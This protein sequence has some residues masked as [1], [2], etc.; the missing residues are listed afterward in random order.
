MNLGAVKKIQK[1]LQAGDVATHSKSEKQAEAFKKQG[2][3]HFRRRELPEALHCYGEVQN[4]YL[5]HIMQPLPLQATFTS[6]WPRA[7]RQRI[8]SHLLDCLEPPKK[9]IAARLFPPDQKADDD[10]EL[11]A[12][13]S[14]LSLCI[15]NRSAV[16]YEM[17]RP[18]V[19]MVVTFT[20]Y[21]ST[22]HLTT[23]S[24]YSSTEG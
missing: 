10:H 18:K 9:H 3:A 1:R 13:V 24:I 22:H 20:A 5:S 17:N 23:Y 2:N 12:S 15:G 6:P 8:L 11:E 14:L 16:L 4:H 7:E 21:H 19:C